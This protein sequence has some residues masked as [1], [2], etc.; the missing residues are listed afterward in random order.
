VAQASSSLREFELVIP[1]REY[2]AM[3]SGV[4]YTLHPANG[5]NR[6]TWAVKGGVWLVKA[7]GLEDEVRLLQREVE[8]LKKR[9][10]ELKRK[11]GGRP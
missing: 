6:Y 10:E 8:W 5:R 2:V 11:S 1:P 3:A 4:E 7:A 9:V